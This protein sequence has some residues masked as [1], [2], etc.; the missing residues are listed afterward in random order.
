MADNDLFTPLSGDYML[1][2]PDTWQVNQQVSNLCASDTDWA[3]HGFYRS[4]PGT[5]CTVSVCAVNWDTFERSPDCISFTPPEDEWQA[6]K[7][8]MPGSSAGGNWLIQSGVSCYD[9]NPGAIF[10]DFV[11]LA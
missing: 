10:V 2:V 4:V 9:S 3:M 1:R 6:V 8:S 5:Q 11:V 7:I